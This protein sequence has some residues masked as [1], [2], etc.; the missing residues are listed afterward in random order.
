MV[1]Q[2]RGVVGLNVGQCLSLVWRSFIPPLTQILDVIIYMELYGKSRTLPEEEILMV[3]YEVTNQYCS[4]FCALLPLPAAAPSDPRSETELWASGRGPNTPHR[5]T[6]P[7]SAPGAGSA[8][9]STLLLEE[10][11]LISEPVL[12][13]Q[14]LRKT[15]TKM[16]QLFSVHPI[17]RSWQTSSNTTGALCVP[18]LLFRWALWCAGW[19][20]L[21]RGVPLFFDLRVLDLKFLNN[22]K[23]GFNLVT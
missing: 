6:A 8:P 15:H 19:S 17:L 23:K 16:C 4:T 18:A 20:G 22:N 21:G 3:L 13:N 10:L 14:P 9:M 5:S 7:P 2:T 11:T 12:P 1:E